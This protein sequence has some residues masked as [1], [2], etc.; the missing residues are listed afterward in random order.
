MNPFCGNMMIAAGG[1]AFL[2]RQF[3]GGTL[4]RIGGV[5]LGVGTSCALIIHLRSAVGTEQKAGKQT[6]LSAFDMSLSVVDPEGLLDKEYP[7]L[8]WYTYP[9]CICI[10]HRLKE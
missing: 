8:M 9:S 10:L 7:S 1:R 5:R 3:I 4:I 6:R 2:P